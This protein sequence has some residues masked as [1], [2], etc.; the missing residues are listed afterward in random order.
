MSPEGYALVRASSDPMAKELAPNR[1]Y[2]LEHRLVMAKHL[3]RPLRSDET[4]HHI[5]GDKADNR[6]E[7]L[8][9]RNGGHGKGKALRCRCCGSSD[10]EEVPLN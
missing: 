5:N 9:I 8:Q 3:G 1:K 10:I 2:V 7:N 4:V 6:I